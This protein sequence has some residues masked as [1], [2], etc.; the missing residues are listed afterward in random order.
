VLSPRQQV[1]VWSGDRAQQWHA[2]VVT[3]DSVS[4]IP[5]VRPVSCDSCRLALP[6]A[7]VDSLRLGSPSTGFWKSVGL[8]AS[9]VVVALV[10]TRGYISE[11]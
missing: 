2:V 3:N 11:D 10:V 8:V 4:G 9:G 5:F 6:R 1:Q 7:A